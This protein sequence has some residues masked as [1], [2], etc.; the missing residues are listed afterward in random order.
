M[1]R[2]SFQFASPEVLKKHGTVSV[3]KAF[4]V[5]VFVNTEVEFA[6]A[7]IDTVSCSELGFVR[8]MLSGI[9]KPFSV[10]MDGT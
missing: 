5:I 3:W 8:V 7:W 6:D 10:A 9:M 4:S 2:N 1:C